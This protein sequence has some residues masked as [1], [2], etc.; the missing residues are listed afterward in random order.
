MFNVTQHAS[1]AGSSS[2][3]GT[4]VH[5]SK[6]CH[7]VEIVLRLYGLG[8]ICALFIGAAI[9]HRGPNVADSGVLDCK[10]LG[11]AGAHC[12]KHAQGGSPSDAG[13]G[14][15]GN[16]ISTGRAGRVCALH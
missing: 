10:N 2:A 11:R 13:F 14:G 7:T 12:V 4:R 1:L 16:C 6:D 15:D 8:L 9:P 3:S 5:R